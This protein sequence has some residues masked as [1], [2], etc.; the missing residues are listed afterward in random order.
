MNPILS[1]DEVA[2]L[3]ECAPKTVENQLRAGELPGVKFGTG[4]ICP[5][6]ALIETLNNLARR[7]LGM[8]MPEEKKPTPEQRTPT[9][10]GRKARPAP[11]LSP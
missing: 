6:E 10:R 3:L 11:S 7:N 8:T 9:P 4:W 2:K 1:I 5:T